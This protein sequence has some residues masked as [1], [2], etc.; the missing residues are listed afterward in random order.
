MAEAEY[1]D[2]HKDRVV[3]DKFIA[4]IFNDIV[5]GKIIKKGPD[6]TLT[7]GLEISRLETTTPQSI[8][9]NV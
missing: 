2:G 5:N 7:Q 4:G 6:M 8:S 1:P 9:Q 3:H